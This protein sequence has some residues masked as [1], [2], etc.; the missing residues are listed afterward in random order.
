MLNN[1]NELIFASS[2]AELIGH[3][4]GLFALLAATSVFLFKKRRGILAA[5]FSTDGL[6]SLHFLLLGQQTAA[7]ITLINVVRGV[8]FYNKGKKWASSNAWCAV[9]IFLSISSAFVNGFNA[10]NILPAIGSSIAVIGLWS[11][12]TL[13]LRVFNLC[14]VSLWLIYTAII[15]SPSAVI[16]NAIYVVTISISLVREIKNRAKAAKTNHEGESYEQA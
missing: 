12:D 11:T 13:T 14:G 6:Y 8:V 3:I 1:I 15:F 7:L 2:E 5:K 4:I 10:V 9:F 16:C